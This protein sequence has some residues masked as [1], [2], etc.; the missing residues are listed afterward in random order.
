MRRLFPTFGA[1]LVASLC[2]AQSES[3]ENFSLSGG[4]ASVVG[5]LYYVN[6]S[7]TGQVMPTRA[8]I[9]STSGLP[10][11]PSKTWA[12]GVRQTHTY[13]A[14]QYISVGSPVSIV[15]ETTGTSTTNRNVLGAFVTGLYTGD[16]SKQ[17]GKYEFFCELRQNSTVLD[18]KTVY[19]TI[20]RY[21][22][23]SGNI[24]SGHSAGGGGVGANSDS[25]EDQNGFWADLFESL[26]VPDPDNVDALIDTL[27]DFTTWGP[28]G[29]YGYLNGQIEA[30]GTSRID[31]DE[32]YKIPFSVPMVGSLELDLTPYEGFI[33]FVRA[34]FAGVLWF[35]VVFAI[36]KRVYQKA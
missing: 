10:G 9:T 12:I 31:Y 21:A 5:T 14:G 2:L 6:D 34:I 18:G 1:V 33:K 15:T 7:A 4:G 16:K 24:I 30:P 35:F 23:E 25:V 28:F 29:I 32:A 3:S 22:S 26:F 20:N 19:C 8:E 11:A 27:D 13:A 36:W 17:L